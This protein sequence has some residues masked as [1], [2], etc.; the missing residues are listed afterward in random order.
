MDEAYLAHPHYGARSLQGVLEDAG[1]PACRS[2]VRR[3][4][5]TM[6]IEALYPKPRLSRNN[7]ENRI[8]PYLLGEVVLERPN[9]VWASD[10]TYIPLRHGFAYLVAVMDWASRYVVSW[11]LSLSLESD[12]CVR[13]LERALAVGR[14]GIFNTDQGCQFTSRAFTERLVSAGVSISMDGKGR[15]FDNILTERLWW[16]VKYED[17]YLKNYVTYFEA[18]DGLEAYFRFYNEE[19]KHTGLGRRTPSSVYWTDRPRAAVAG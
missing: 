18:N 8:Y 17:V 4:M 11:S 12:F 16:S 19:R 14:P 6:G 15:C 7:G 3:L 13:T 5:R 2:H 1:C 9:Q 10:I